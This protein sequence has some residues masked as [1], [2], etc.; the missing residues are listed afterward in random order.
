[1]NRDAITGDLREIL[2]GLLRVPVLEGDD[3]RALGVDSIVTM[4]M[5]AAVQNK[6]G[7]EIPLASAFMARNVGELADTIEQAISRVSAG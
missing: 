6:F 5:V 3:F 2:S 4:R 7:V 1:L